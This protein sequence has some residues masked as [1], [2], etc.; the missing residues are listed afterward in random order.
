MDYIEARRIHTLGIPLRIFR[1]SGEAEFVCIFSEVPAS[2]LRDH[3][4]GLGSTSRRFYASSVFLSVFSDEANLIPRPNDD[5]LF[6]I[7]ADSLRSYD[8]TIVANSVLIWSDG[9]DMRVPPVPSQAPIVATRIE[10]VLNG[11]SFNFG[12]ALTLP[13]GDRAPFSV[14][15]WRY[16]LKH[17]DL[18]HMQ[19]LFL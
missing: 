4:S 18:S 16:G 17:A 8:V 10:D 11:V 2:E 14:R 5:D 1:L 6:L 7:P 9:Q 3:R 12:A 19:H 13:S 15:N